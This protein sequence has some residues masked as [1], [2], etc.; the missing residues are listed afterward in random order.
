MTA[1][2]GLL[3]ASALLAGFIMVA[4]GAAAAVP[5]SA[6]APALPDLGSAVTVSRLPAGGTAIVRPT[7]GAPLAAVELWY[8]APS[9]GFGAKAQPGLA[10]L[11]AQAVAAS[12]P[13]IGKSL[14]QTVA[15][16]GGRLFITVYSD[17]LEVSALVPATSAGDVVKTMTTA[18]FAPVLTEAGFTSAQRDVAAEALFASV[19]V[20]TVVRDAL[21]AQ[22]FSDG[23]QHFPTLAP[24]RAL[25]ALAFPDVQSFALRAFRSPNATLV[26]SGAVDPN[27]AQAAATGRHELDA[28]AEAPLVGRI[29]AASSPATLASVQRSGGFGWLG[30]PIADER[31]ATAMDF[32]SD[33]LFRADSGTVVAQAARRYP[34]TLLLGGFI[35]LHDP[36]VM[37]VAYGGNDGTGV[38]KLVTDAIAAVQQPLPPA[39]FAAARAAFEFH[40]LDDLQTP[41]QLADSFGW[42]TVEGN[43]P[44]APGA[45]GDRGRYFAIADALTPEFVAAVAR[46]YLGRTPATVTLAPYAKAAAP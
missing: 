6:T 8:R 31:E 20:E 46:K 1:A 41:L 9:I 42:Y 10:R 38:R 11:A 34:N 16:A 2:G 5:P 17:S 27:I 26:L 19:D 18:Y 24:P 4:A 37:F 44:Y 33:Y 30:P 36:G 3:R 25:A 22:L 28:S 15:D 35:T 14:A 12:K 7:E 23:P 21:F 32:I 43:P 45:V 39:T 13:I 40:L 29:S